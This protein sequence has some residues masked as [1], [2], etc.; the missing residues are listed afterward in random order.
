MATGASLVTAINRIGH[1]RGTKTKE[2][3]RALRQSGFKVR[4]NTLTRFNANRPTPERCV[5]KILLE[6]S[7]RIWGHWVLR[8]DGRDYDPA[9]RGTIYWTG[10]KPRITGYLEIE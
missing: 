9:D 1:Q 5:L 4:R 8:W 2:L 6:N 7:E 3:A 10:M